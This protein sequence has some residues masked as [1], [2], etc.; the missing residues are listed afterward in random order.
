MADLK[1]EPAT[2]R[3]RVAGGRYDVEQSAWGPFITVYF[4]T[5]DHKVDIVEPPTGREWADLKEARAA[6]K[7]HNEKRCAK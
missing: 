2:F 3:A 5:D 7:T 6:C 1:F 4:I